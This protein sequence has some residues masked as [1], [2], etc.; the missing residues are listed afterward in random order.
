MLTNRG[1]YL[2]KQK[3]VL[4]SRGLF[5]LC[6]QKTV[7]TNRCRDNLRTPYGVVPLEVS[8]PRKM[9]DKIV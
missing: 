5:C 6:K 7:L 4:T 1:L 9:L 2:C 8:E 3:T